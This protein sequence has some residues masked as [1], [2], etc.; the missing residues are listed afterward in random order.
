VRDLRGFLM[1][2]THELGQNFYPG[3]CISIPSL[4]SMANEAQKTVGANIQ[5]TPLEAKRWLRDHYF[6]SC[7]LRRTGQDVVVDPTGVPEQQPYRRG[8]VI[9]PYF[10]LAESAVGTHQQTYSI[11][12]PL[13]DWGVRDFPPR[14]RP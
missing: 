4:T 3:N 10:G 12:K 13:D 8:G 1:A 9:L 2:L 5:F 14:F 6:W 7:K 11:M